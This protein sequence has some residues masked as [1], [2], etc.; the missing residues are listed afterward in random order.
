MVHWENAG[1]RSERR[2]SQEHQYL[3][4]HRC[5]SSPIENWCERRAEAD[6]RAKN[7]LPAATI[8]V[9]HNRLDLRYR[10]STVWSDFFRRHDL[11]GLY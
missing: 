2:V 3:S 8:K 6:M 1:L 4:A 5:L 10:S 11:P 7:G 9:Q